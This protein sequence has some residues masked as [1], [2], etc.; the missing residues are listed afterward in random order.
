MLSEP[1]P[2]HKSPLKNPLLYS[3]IILVAVVI[4]V[5]LVMYSRWN[6]ARIRD[7][8][9]A[10]ERAEKQHEEDRLAVEQ[11]GGKDFAI[12]NFYASPKAIRRGETA[13]LCYGVSNAKNVT[14]EPQ[15]QAVWP[16]PANCV[17]VSPTKTT[18]YTLT[19]LDAAGH[20]LSQ[21]L[22]LAVR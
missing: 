19:I 17:T 13:K 16:S 2:E 21:T 9:A 20:S 1:T 12:L 10:K 14:L 4:A 18:T 5:G 22:D 11:L 8:A 6:D 7:A 3:S 15:P